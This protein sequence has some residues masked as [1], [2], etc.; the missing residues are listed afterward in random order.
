[1]YYGFRNLAQDYLEVNPGYFLS[2]GKINGSA[3]ETLFSQFKFS[4]AGKLS[5]INYATARRAFLIKRDIHGMHFSH[6]DYRSTPLAVAHMV[7]EKGKP[8]VS[9]TNVKSK[10]Y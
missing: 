3:V 8:K 4:A 5:G 10:F 1:M 2:P 9:Q 6:G 7:L